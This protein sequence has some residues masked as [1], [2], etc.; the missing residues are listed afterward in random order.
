MQQIFYDILDYAH[1][2]VRHLFVGNFPVLLLL[3]VAVVVLGVL[4]FRN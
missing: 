2:G 3:A 4:I 1:D